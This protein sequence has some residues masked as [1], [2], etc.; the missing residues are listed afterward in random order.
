M[1]ETNKKLTER[2]QGEQGTIDLQ[3]KEKQDAMDTKEKNAKQRK[4][5][6]MQGNLDGLRGVEIGVERTERRQMQVSRRYRGTNQRH[7][8]IISIN[9]PSCREAVEEVGEISIDPPGIEKL[10]RR[11][12]HQVLR[13]YRDC[14]KKKLKKLDR[15]QGIEEVSS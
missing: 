3:E 13:S 4:M 1:T 11:Q 12:I 8:N 10:S 6:C 7:K 2:E 15:Q 9:R 14:D 5:K